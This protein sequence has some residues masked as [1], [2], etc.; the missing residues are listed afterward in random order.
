M[1]NAVM[2]ATAGPHRAAEVFRRPTGIEE[3]LA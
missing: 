1:G 3:A 2:A